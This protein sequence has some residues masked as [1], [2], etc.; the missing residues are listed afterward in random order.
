MKNGLL[1]SLAFSVTSLL[2]CPPPL[3]AGVAVDPAAAV[4]KAEADWAAA[5]GAANVGAWMSFY[6][7]DAIVLLPNDQLANG[8]ELVHQAVSRLLALPHLSVTWRPIEANVARSGDLA[9]LVE[10]YELRFDD[11]RGV[12]VSD[13]G[14]RLEIWR[15]QADSSW[16]CIVDTWNL[17][18]PIAAPP[19]ES[20]HFTSPTAGSAAP[21]APGEPPPPAAPPES[22]PP[23]PAPALGAATK[24][25]DMPTNYEEAIRQ[26]YRAH[27][28]HPESVEYREI[29]QPREG[30]TTEITGALLMREKREYGWTV[31]AT[32]NA[33]DS[34]DSYVGFKTYTFLFRGEK[35]VDARLPLPGDE[36]N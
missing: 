7:A 14:R 35:I 8:K 1:A 25:G 29:T 22:G 27:L 17:D 18:A 30:Y 28:K 36:M 32:I 15:K 19:P 2:V 4:R 13:R 20:A 6:A 3:S 31:K 33:K 9:F 5:G 12:P 23:A 21:P 24:Y 11:S 10:A 26:Y 34:H 16:K